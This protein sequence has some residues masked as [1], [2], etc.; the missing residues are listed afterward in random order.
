MKVLYKEIATSNP[1]DEIR[2]GIAS[3]DDGSG[4]S[5]SVKYTWFDKRGHACRGGE[6]PIEA[7]AQL[8]KVAKNCSSKIT[9]K[10]EG[11]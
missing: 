8:V 5:L 7:L 11:V 4:K 6:V 1:Q 10:K 2:F 3:W 9:M